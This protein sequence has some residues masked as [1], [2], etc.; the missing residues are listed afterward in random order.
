MVKILTR[1]TKSNN[2]EQHKNSASGTDG[3]TTRQN[4][5]IFVE[6]RTRNLNIKVQQNMETAKKEKKAH[7]AKV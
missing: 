6:H 1:T 5:A 2:K 3:K 7:C 4:H